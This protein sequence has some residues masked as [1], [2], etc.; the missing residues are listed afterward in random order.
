LVGMHICTDY[1]C[2]ILMTSRNSTNIAQI[3]PDLGDSA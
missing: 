2:R 3:M 1:F